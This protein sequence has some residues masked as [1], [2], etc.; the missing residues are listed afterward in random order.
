MYSNLAAELLVWLFAAAVFTKPKM[1][2]AA[3]ATTTAVRKNLR[4]AG[5]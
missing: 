5:F 1:L 2:V 4:A 3:M